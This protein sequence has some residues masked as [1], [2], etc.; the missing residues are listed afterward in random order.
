MYGKQLAGVRYLACQ[1][2]VT[3]LD[4]GQF[5]LCLVNVICQLYDLSKL[6]VTILQRLADLFSKSL[7]FD[8]EL[9]DVLAL[10]I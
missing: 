7:Y 3:F 4:A 6:H 8:G 5:L 2:I 1:L 9:I 10:G